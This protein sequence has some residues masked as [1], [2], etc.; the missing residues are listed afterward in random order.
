MYRHICRDIYR[1]KW[2]RI[3]CYNRRCMFLCMLLH[4]NLCKCRYSSSCS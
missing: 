2:I 1:C 3:L 4:M